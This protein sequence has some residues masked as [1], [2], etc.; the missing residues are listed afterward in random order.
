LSF[1]IGGSIVAVTMC[2]AKENDRDGSR[3]SA[4]VEELTEF[5]DEETAINELLADGR[6]RHTR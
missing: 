4:V 3:Q 5:L 6:S 1:Q 2:K